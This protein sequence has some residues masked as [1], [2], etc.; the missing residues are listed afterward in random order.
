[1][2]GRYSVSLTGPLTWRLHSHF[3]TMGIPLPP[4]PIRTTI[5]IQTIIRAAISA[6]SQQL[7]QLAIF[8]RYAGIAQAQTS[9]PRSVNSART[10][11]S[12]LPSSQDPIR[13][14]IVGTASTA[15]GAAGIRASSVECRDLVLRARQPAP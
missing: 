6:A 12:A 3:P 8:Y 7:T 4:R 15:I 2:L 11:W 14:N 9:T 13:V 1:M 10:R 5:P